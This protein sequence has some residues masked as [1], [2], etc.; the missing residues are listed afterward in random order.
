MMIILIFC[1]ILTYSPVSDNG[2]IDSCTTERYHSVEDMAD[3]EKYYYQNGYM[4]ERS[5]IYEDIIYIIREYKKDRDTKIMLQNILVRHDDIREFIEKSFDIDLCKNFYDGKLRV[6]SWDNLI[7]RSSC[8]TPTWILTSAYHLFKELS[9]FEDSMQ[10][11]YHNKKPTQLINEKHIERMKKYND[12]G[13]NI[14]P[15]KNFT[16]ICELFTKHMFKYR[17]E[18]EYDHTYRL[19]GMKTWKNFITSDLYEEYIKLL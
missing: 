12:R 3:M 7:N 13:F 8:I 16:E 6:F 2:Y 11:M 4:R 1:H 5:S 18:E 10:I 15:H 17:N 9:Y 14:Y 19:D